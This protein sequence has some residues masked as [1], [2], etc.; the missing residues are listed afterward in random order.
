[1]L[2]C[3]SIEKLHEY[4]D[5][6]ERVPDITDT[7]PDEDQDMEEVDTA[8]QQVDSTSLETPTDF[9]VSHS[10][11]TII[12]VLIEPFGKGLLQYNYILYIYF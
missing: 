5:S 3:C 7:E 6:I 2:R 10:L 8:I 12:L 4:I 11:L 9:N 1:M